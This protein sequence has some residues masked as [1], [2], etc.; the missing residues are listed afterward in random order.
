M[1]GNLPVGCGAVRLELIQDLHGCDQKCIMVPGLLFCGALHIILSVFPPFYT[2]M[3]IGLC[4]PSRKFQTA[5][6]ISGYS[7]SVGP[8]NGTCIILS[9]W[10]LEFGLGS[11]TSGKFL[12]TWHWLCLFGCAISTLHSQCCENFNVTCSFILLFCCL[13]SLQYVQYTVVLYLI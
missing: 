5:V 1:E 9:F 13:L 11:W 8:W 6:R 12:V 2:K 10:H 4:A 3:C 7:R